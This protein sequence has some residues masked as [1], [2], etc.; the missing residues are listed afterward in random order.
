MRHLFAA[1]LSFLVTLPVAARADLPHGSYKFVDLPLGRLEVADGEYVRR[2]LWNGQQVGDETG[3]IEING[4]Y[5]EPGASHYFV[6]TT[7]HSGGNGCFPSMM[8]LR[9]GPDGLRR[10]S[11]FGTC[12]G[13]RALRLS[14]GVFELDQADQRLF[15]SHKTYAYDGVTLTESETPIPAPT[16]QGLGGGADVTRWLGAY[17][18]DVLHDPGEQARFLRIA[19][20]NTLESLR[21]HVD[22]ANQ[23]VQRGDWLL[24]AGC[25]PHRCN[26]QRGFWGIRISTGD[27]V[28]VLQETGRIDQMYGDGF[29]LADG[30]IRQFIEERRPR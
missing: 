17:P 3:D 24:G 13:V 27:P 22:V 16:D 15:V 19:D 1:L 21:V 10:T 4:V 18:W 6:L 23:V 30:T 9:I 5:T 20:M 11:I 14:G 29:D 26:S 12:G 7:H 8:M 25:F 2:L 28:I